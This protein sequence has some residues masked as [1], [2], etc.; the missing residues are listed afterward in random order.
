MEIFETNKPTSVHIN[1][2]KSGEVILYHNE[3]YIKT[4]EDMDVIIN[5]RD[6]NVHYISDML[7]YN[8]ALVVKVK[9]HLTID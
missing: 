7:D 8:D 3:Y 1:E 9:A 6:G 4:N 2:V 5:L